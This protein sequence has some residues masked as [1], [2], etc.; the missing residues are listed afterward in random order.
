[1]ASASAALAASSSSMSD[2]GKNAPTI[3]IS[4]GSMQPVEDAA[5][6]LHA[7]RLV[8]KD[9]LAPLHLRGRFAEIAVSHVVQHVLPA[10]I[11]EQLHVFFLM[12][13]AFRV[14]I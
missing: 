13:P 12:G 5:E 1:M 3:R 11:A 10:A 8:A 4:S 7:R 2:S 9:F 14:I 6:H